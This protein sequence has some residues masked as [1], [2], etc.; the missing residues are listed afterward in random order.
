MDITDFVNSSYVRYRKALFSLGGENHWVLKEQ[1][2][3]VNKQY[4]NAVIEA[5][6][7]ACGLENDL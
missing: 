5:L 4:G 2:E 6:Q 7:I 1:E 3:W